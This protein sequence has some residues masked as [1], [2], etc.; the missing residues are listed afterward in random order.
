VLWE[1][2][3]EYRTFPWPSP[4]LVTVTLSNVPASVRP[5]RKPMTPDVKWSSVRWSITLPSSE[6]V[7]RSPDTAMDTWC[8]DPATSRV[9]SGTGASAV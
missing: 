4:R 3:L 2:S 8:M 9:P 7:I 6:V 1:K 5:F